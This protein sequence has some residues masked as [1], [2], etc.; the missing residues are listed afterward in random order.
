MSN[1]CIPH[2]SF[3]NNNFSKSSTFIDNDIPTAT[4][5]MQ[6]QEVYDVGNRNITTNG[7]K[8]NNSFK[9]TLINDDSDI[10]NIGIVKTKS[11]LFTE[12]LK[13]ATSYYNDNSIQLENRFAPLRFNKNIY[14]KDEV[15]TVI[16]EDS[17]D[18]IPSPSTNQSPIVHQTRPAV[19]INEFPERDIAMKPIRP[20][21][22]NSYSEAVIKGKKTMI[23]STSMTKGIRH[24]EFNN[25]IENG[26]AIFQRF[27]GA[28]ARHVKNYIATHLSEQQ[29]DTVIL[30]AGGNDLPTKKDNPIPVEDIA[31]HI[32]EAGNVCSTYG[33]KNVLISGV[34]TRRT[35]YMA[36]RCRELNNILKGMCQVSNFIFI[37]NSNIYFQHLAG[38][39]VHLNED[40]NINLANNFLNAL[41]DI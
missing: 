37:E 15:D 32:I 36:K 18:Y 21:T 38:D 6:W 8:H 29:P 41:N 4:D 14:E 23:F 1:D 12:N 2:S 26:H 9:R 16:S 27:H 34:I 11:T 39:G 35:P 20:G 30:L 19:V 5:Y 25:Y 7:D 17:E 33:V 3:N 10:E 31:S 22:A 24:Q 28:K 13:K 40:G